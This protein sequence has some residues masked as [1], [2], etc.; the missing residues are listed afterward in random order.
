MEFGGDHGDSQ[1][2]V[3]ERSRVRS[4][5]GPDL[6]DSPNIFIEEIE[7]GPIGRSFTTAASTQSEKPDG[8]AFMCLWHPTDDNE[9]CQEHRVTKQVGF[10]LSSTLSMKLTIPLVLTRPHFQG[11]S[12]RPLVLGP[13]F[14]LNHMVMLTFMSSL[15]IR[16]CKFAVVLR[17]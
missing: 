13:T 16:I 4:Y 7:E 3:E 1:P 15:Y 12:C 9:T 17:D 10:K 8:M 6:G 14:E 11:S 2:I 5:D